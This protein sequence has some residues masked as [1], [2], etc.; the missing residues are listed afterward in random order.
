MTAGRTG[1]GQLGLG[2]DDDRRRQDGQLGLGDRGPEMRNDL[3]SVSLG[4]GLTALQ[5]SKGPKHTCAL[6][7][8][9]QLKCWGGCP[10]P[11]FP[12]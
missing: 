1:D 9:G 5:V 3:E 12:S 11:P 7:S 8:N 6:L 10:I 4:Q 2:N